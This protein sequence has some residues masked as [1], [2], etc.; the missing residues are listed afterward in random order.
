M[1]AKLISPQGEEFELTDEQFGASRTNGTNSTILA[2]WFKGGRKEECRGGDKGG[3]P[4]T[5]PF[6]QASL[7]AFA[8]SCPYGTS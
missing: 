7:T 8:C 1:V 3:T 2:P 5:R 4:D 6:G